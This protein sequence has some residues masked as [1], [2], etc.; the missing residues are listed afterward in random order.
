ML[1]SFTSTKTKNTHLPFYAV[2]DVRRRNL[3]LI[4]IVILSA[5]V[6]CK[7]TKKKRY[8]YYEY[9]KQRNIYFKNSTFTVHK[10]KIIYL[11][12]IQAC[13]IQ[14]LYE[15][16]G[17]FWTQETS[18]ICSCIILRIQTDD[19]HDWWIHKSEFSLEKKKK[20]SYDDKR[21]MTNTSR[22]IAD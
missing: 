3:C 8:K 1:R 10:K 13:C 18:L 6:S 2:D 11:S 22:D 4:G 14:K 21:M 16:A 19:W 9:N 20:I 17:T 5:A 15:N 12:T 7:K